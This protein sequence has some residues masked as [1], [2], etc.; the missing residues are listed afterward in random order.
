MTSSAATAHPA[1]V[2]IEHII[3]I[4]KDNHT[5][6]NL[7][8]QFTGV[9]GLDRSGARIQQVD[10]EGNTYQPLPQPLGHGSPDR[11]FPAD[12]PNAPFSINGYAPPTS[13]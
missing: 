12:L 7:Y 11:R 13:W 3:V 5:F 10:R 8:G 1:D 9:N 4:Y 6:D 2:P